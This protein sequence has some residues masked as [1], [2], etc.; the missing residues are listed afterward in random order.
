[1]SLNADPLCRYREQNLR[2]P[3]ILSS[4]QQAASAPI[5]EAAKAQPKGST[6]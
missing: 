1:M 2:L 4:L 6:R 5:S 3:F